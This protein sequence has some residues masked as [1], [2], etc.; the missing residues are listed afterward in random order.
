M[1]IYIYICPLTVFHGVKKWW[2]DE[3]EYEYGGEMWGVGC[4]VK[5]NEREG[6]GGKREKK[7]FFFFQ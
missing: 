5:G 3:Y 6:E 1:Y 4:G 2:M 7:E